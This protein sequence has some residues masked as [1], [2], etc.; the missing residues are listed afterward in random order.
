M[1]TFIYSWIPQAVCSTEQHKIFVIQIQDCIWQLVLISSYSRFVV[2]IFDCFFV[3]NSGCICH[4]GEAQSRGVSLFSG[5]L[6]KNNNNNNKKNNPTV[7]KWNRRMQAPV[8]FAHL[9]PLTIHFCRSFDSHCYVRARTL[10]GDKCLSGIGYCNY[11]RWVEINTLYFFKRQQSAKKAFYLW[12]S[13]SR[14]IFLEKRQSFLTGLN[15]TSFP[16]TFSSK[17]F[18][19]RFWW[20]N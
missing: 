6:F 5:W 10:D 11:Y 8:L 15:E 12:W 19:I 16:F 4:K 18:Y 9:N 20:T 17:S 3:M 7:Q 1:D 2:I 13:L 14:V